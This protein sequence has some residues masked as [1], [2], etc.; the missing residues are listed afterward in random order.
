ML[1]IKYE[2]HGNDTLTSALKIMDD[3]RKF[4]DLINYNFLPYNMLEVLLFK[5]L[6]IKLQ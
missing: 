6:L 5:A 2:I 3:L 4:L 1:I